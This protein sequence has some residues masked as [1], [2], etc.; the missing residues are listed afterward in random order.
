MYGISFAGYPVMMY[1]I[2]IDRAVKPTLLFLRPDYSYGGDIWD[3]LHISCDGVGYDIEARQPGREPH[4]YRHTISWF[5]R[6][7][8]VEPPL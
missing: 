6:S 8:F 3:F 4:L 5:Y 1:Q 2:R 7:Y